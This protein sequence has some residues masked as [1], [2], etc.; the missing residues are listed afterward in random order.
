MVLKDKGGRDLREKTKGRRHNPLGSD[1]E[2]H[3]LA[4]RKGQDLSTNTNNQDEK[5]VGYVHDK[6]SKKIIKQAQLQQRE[7]EAEEQGN[8]I[9]I[10]PNEYNL[11]DEEVDGEKL[12][13]KD[14]TKNNE[15]MEDLSDNENDP[16]EFFESMQLDH[17]DEQALHSFMSKSTPK[18]LT[19][20]DMIMSKI[21]DRKT[22]IETQISAVTSKSD[23]GVAGMDPRIVKVYQSVGMLLSKYRSGK[24]PKAFKVIPTLTNWE[25]ILYL[26]YPESWSA[27][28]MYQATRIFVSNLKSNMAQRFFNLVLLPRVRDDIEEYKKLNVHLYNALKKAFFKP[29]AFFKGILLP[30]CESGTCTLREAVIFGSILSKISVPMLHS[31]AALLRIAEMEYTGSTSIFIRVLIDK[32]YALPY[33][34]V[35]ALVFHFLQAKNDNREYPVLWHQS[36][37]AFVERYKSDVSIEQKEALLQVTKVQTHYSISPEIQRELINSTSREDAIKALQEE[38]RRNEAQFGSKSIDQRL[39]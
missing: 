21:S 2:N 33:R 16:E 14:P 8:G 6:L 39:F 34:V 36:F 31:A 5:N 28:A 10:K 25:E 15:D 11:E 1:I 18:R 35:D 19:L 4:K 23:M 20:A 17:K 22:E 26:T 29:D 24:L 7:I 27:A 32:K 13:I 12:N 3:R 38:K 9:A 30:L 37:L